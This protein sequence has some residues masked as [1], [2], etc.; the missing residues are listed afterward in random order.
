MPHMDVIHS[1]NLGGEVD[2]T[3][4]C[5]AL[6]G[7]MARTGMFPL[8]GIRVRAIESAHVLIADGHP[9]NSFAHLALAVGAGRSAEA[10]RAA[11]EEIW[12]EAV[13]FLGPLF[14]TPHFALS[15]EMREIDPEF[16]WKKNSIHARLSAGER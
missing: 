4:F 10:R 3:S 5:A 9:A 15:M 16:S 2:L 14:E 12:A 13:R 8:G 6:G 7:A 11:G 1:R